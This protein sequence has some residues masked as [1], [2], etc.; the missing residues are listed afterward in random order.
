[1]S[2]NLLNPKLLN[3]MS[4]KNPL[5]PQNPSATAFHFINGEFSPSKDGRTFDSINPANGDVLCKVALGG[6][7]E[8]AAAVSAAEVA[9]REGPWS[10]TT[11]TERAVMLRKIGD[12]LLARKQEFAEL[13]SMDSGKP[14]SETL[15]ADIPRA[16]FNFHFYADLCHHQMSPSFRSDDGS[17]HITVREPLGVVGLITP[18]NL[19]LYLAAWKLAPA[20][21]QGNS[22][23]LKPAELTPLT[24]Y[25]LAEV[26]KKVGLPPGV[27][28][29]VQGFGPDSAGEALV[30]H[31]GVKAIS[32]TGETSTGSAIMAAGSPSLKKMS[33]ELGG[34][35]ASIIFADADIERAAK[36]ATRAA[37]R[38]QGQV[39]LAGSR[40]L[41]EESVAARVIEIVKAELAKI[42][43]GDPLD[44]STT[45][46]ALC[47]VEHRNKVKGF[48]DH[49]RTIPGVKIEV[50]GQIPAHM[51][52]AG[53]WFEPTLITN[54]PQDSRLIQEEIFGPVLTV[55]TF[56]TF[57][58]AI[59]MVNGTKYGLSCS[60]WTKD[61]DKA[62]HAANKIRTGLV[63]INCWFIRNLHTAFGGMKQSGVGRE[64]GQT[65]L[66]FFSEM[67]TICVA[68]SLHERHGMVWI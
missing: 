28:N 19:P 5:L 60:V 40:L 33:F 47:G 25:A 50:G 2:H 37:M 10:K 67:K 61:I 68:N 9:W 57:D 59:A 1:M 39:C 58:E 34:K 63:W 21:A 54:V 36:V 56:K 13:E 66:D 44:A 20:L 3:P 53:A 26:F 31:P 11:S 7:D 55:Q 27:V 24:A 64:G 6:A 65:S 49:A 42:K 15:N 38:N 30:K 16:A 48:V 14:L 62:N 45:L 46:G 35:G 23:V 12:E 43:I 8:V 18:W 51:P 52:K 4:I 32:F 29:I 17:H 41:V 22:V